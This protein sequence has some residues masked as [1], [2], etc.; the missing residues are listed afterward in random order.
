MRYVSAAI[1]SVGLTLYLGGTVIL[2][3]I[4]GGVIFPENSQPVSTT[5]N[6]CL[7]PV[8]APVPYCFN[9]FQVRLSSVMVD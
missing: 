6:A 7:A 5:G 8:T 3:D 4:L 1:L 2:K 9:G